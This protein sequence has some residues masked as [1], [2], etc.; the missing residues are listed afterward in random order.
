M[1]DNKTTLPAKLPT[2]LFHAGHFWNNLQHIAPAGVTFEQVSDPKYWQHVAAL[3]KRRDIVEVLADDNSFEARFRVLN[4]DKGNLTLRSIGK[5][6]A[7]DTAPGK[8]A[9]STGDQKIVDGLEISFANADRH[10]VVDVAT[11]EVVSKGHATRAEAEQ[12]RANLLA[13]RKAA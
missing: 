4:A 5:V 9:T 10:R 6:T 8:S 12:A 2:Q 11:K 3:L 7:I 1:P 13:A